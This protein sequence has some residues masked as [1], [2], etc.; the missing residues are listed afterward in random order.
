MADNCSNDGTDMRPWLPIA[1]ILLTLASNASAGV[2]LTIV[3][4]SGGSDSGVSARNSAAAEARRQVTVAQTEFTR[5]YNQAVLNNPHA[6]DLKQARIDLAKAHRQLATATSDA[7]AELNKQSDYRAVN[8]DIW[9]LE[10]K[11]SR[12]RDIAKRTEIAHQLFDLRRKRSTI[13]SE[14]FSNDA[15]ITVANAGV[16][17]AM[18]ALRNAEQMYQWH[19]TKDAGFTA[20]KSNLDAARERLANLNS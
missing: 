18:N 2:Y 7:K 3:R 17:E 16:M 9:G 4:R 20:A 13:E 8:I 5:A 1:L 14:A 6:Y 19:L 10:D 12:E 15:S 11:L